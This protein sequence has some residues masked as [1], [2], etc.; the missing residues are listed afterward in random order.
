MLT[1]SPHVAPVMSPVCSYNEWDP[2]EEVIV[3]VADGAA[4]PH[5]HST[6]KATMPSRQ[7]KFFQQRGGQPFPSDDVI[8]A[9]ADLA[10]LVHILEAEGVRVRRPE[11][12]DH[13]RPYATPDWASPGGLYSAM[14]RDLLLVVGDEIIETP[15]A[16]RSRYFEVHAYRPLLREYF[17]SGARWSAAPRPQLSDELYEADYDEP[18]PGAPMRYVINELEPTFDA[19]DFIR[20]GRDLFYIRSHVTNAS[21][22]AWLA[23]HL[24]PEYRLHELTCTDTHPMHIDTTF[25]PIGPGKLLVNPDRVRTVPPVLRGWDIFE[26][27]RPCT[28]DLSRLYMSGPWLSMNV[29]MLD[30]K[31]VIVAAHEETLIRAFRSWG[32]QPIACPFDGFYRLGGSMHCATLDVRRRGTLQSYL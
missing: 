2:L 16:W 8:R 7:W 10:A 17:R 4:V 31:R 30:E 29:L 32:L 26:A 21:G 13:A 24:G 28:T 25:L 9:S 27:P 19:A 18:P 15:M 3:G 12:L 20:C 23:R 11:P 6:L 22:V 14:P 5:W 1:T